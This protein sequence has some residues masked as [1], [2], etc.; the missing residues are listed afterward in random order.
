MRRGVLPT[1]HRGVRHSSTWRPS[2]PGITKVKHLP[3]SVRKAAGQGS[4]SLG[5]LVDAHEL[6]RGH[7]GPTSASASATR[8]GACASRSRSPAAT[9]ALL[10][11]RRDISRNSG[12]HDQP[13]DLGHS[14]WSRDAYSLNA[15]SQ[16]Q[17][18]ALL[19]NQAPVDHTYQQRAGPLEGQRAVGSRTIGARSQVPRSAWTCRALLDRVRRRVRAGNEFTRPAWAAGE[20]DEPGAW[21]EPARPD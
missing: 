3:G 12:P 20:R 9:P 17:I 11:G 21:S 1:V 19:L 14:R 7:E 15:S 16:P 13:H 18:V 2:T 8:H 4:A 6:Q 5:R 10:A